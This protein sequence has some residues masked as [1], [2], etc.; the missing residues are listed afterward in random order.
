MRL[1]VLDE[2]LMWTV[3]LA[4][5]IRALGYEAIVWSKPTELPL[6]PAIADAAIINLSSMVFPAETW[7]PRLKQVGIPILA[8][9]GHKETEKRQLANDL[10]CDLLVT[11]RQL[12]ER[13]D[14]CLQKLGE[15]TSKN[16]IS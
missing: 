2:N 14:E 3:R 11:N 8:H 1:L 5:G 16:P 9:A 10:D 13:L 6:H 12:T 7:V 4:N 15:S